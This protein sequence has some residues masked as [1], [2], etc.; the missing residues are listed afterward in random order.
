[1]KSPS[2]LEGIAN[3]AILTNASALAASRAVT[4][5]LGV[6]Y[7]SFAARQ[8]PPS[9]V[10]FAAASIAAMTLLATVGVLGVGTLLMNEIPR[11]PGE[12]RSLIS[13]AMLVAAAGGA[14]LGALFAILAHYAS[15]DF[16]PLA[17]GWQSG[18]LFALGVSLTAI[19][20]VLDSA[21]IGWLR[22]GLQLKRNAVFAATKLAA[23]VLM[24]T[25]LAGRDGLTIYATWAVGNLVSLIGLAGPEAWSRTRLCTYRPRWGV[26]REMG[27][28]A[29]AHHVLNL[30]L[31]APPLT[32]SLVVTGLLS[33]TTNAY[34]YTAWM[35]ASFLF[36]GPIALATA[37]QPVGA[38]APSTVAHRLRF[39]L[40]ASLLVSL[41]GCLVLLVSADWLL[42]IFGHAYAQQAGWSLRILGLGIFPLIVKEHYVVVCRI[43]GRMALATV[44]V[45]AGGLL[46]VGLAAA[47]AVVGGLPGLSVGWV[48]GVCVQALLMAPT[49][50]DA[51]ADRRSAGLPSNPPWR[52]LAGPTNAVLSAGTGRSAD[53]VPEQRISPRDTYSSSAEHLDAGHGAT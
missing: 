14:G 50:Y 15:A 22:G 8:F 28:A 32:L 18:G 30:A 2:W 1:M 16:E 53:H 39:A 5:I 49:V 34:F 43:S 24:G 19:T 48:I 46:E 41:V 37:F 33:A 29:L 31:Q 27:R 51:A 52:M 6:L 42:D 13:A 4:S 44:A 7:W 21:L 12:E 9:A 45:A 3:R 36:V 25:W 23:L 10:G 47:G 11:R 40:A 26:L 17:T 38:G 35:V 20:L